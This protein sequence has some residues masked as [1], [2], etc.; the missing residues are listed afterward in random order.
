MKRL[1]HIVV[2]ALGLTLGIAPAMAAPQAYKLRVD[3]LAC[4]FCA[5]GI[6][7]KLGAVKGVERIEVDIAS[8]TV[9]VTMAEGATLD[10]EAAKKAVK[11]AGFSLRSF[12]PV[13]TTPQGT[14]GGQAK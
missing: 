5:Y 4:P 1:V 11:E 13:P 7:K 6:E 8:G 3:G 14:A 2:L 12:E 10:E 9:A